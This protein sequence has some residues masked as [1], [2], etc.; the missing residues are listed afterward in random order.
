MLNTKIDQALDL[1]REKKKPT[2]LS[3]SKTL[4]WDIN[5]LERLMLILENSDIVELHYPATL[6]SPPYVTLGKTLQSPSLSSSGPAMTIDQAISKSAQPSNKDSASVEE[7]KINSAAAHV[8][9]SVQIRSGN[10]E[11]RPGYFLT[12]EEVSRHTRAY[13]EYVKVEVAASIPVSGSESSK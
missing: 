9:A 10:G 6:I 1:I 2:L 13:L 12:L 4:N 3:I 11:K 8:K 5:A 7:Y